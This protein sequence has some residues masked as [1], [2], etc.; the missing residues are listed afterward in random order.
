VLPHQLT[1]VP[2]MILFELLR[3]L[4]V[5][6]I[7]SSLLHLALLQHLRALVQHRM[8]HFRV[9][10]KRYVDGQCQSNELGSFW[11]L[12]FISSSLQPEEGVLLQLFM[13]LLGCRTRFCG[14]VI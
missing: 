9:T 11:N 10:L 3:M 4:L 6:R 2:L 7:T 1:T 14:N 8:D 12:P 13:P 5:Q